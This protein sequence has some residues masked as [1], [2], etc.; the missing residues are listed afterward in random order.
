MLL[1]QKSDCEAVLDRLGIGMR[2]LE[3]LCRT[4]EIC[5][6]LFEVVLQLFVI[7]VELLVELNL[8][9]LNLVILLPRV[10][11]GA[12][13]ADLEAVMLNNAGEVLR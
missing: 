1:A 9:P 6:C 11:F 3:F 4:L 13:H 2:F 7:A 5:T 10:R 8:G 12:L